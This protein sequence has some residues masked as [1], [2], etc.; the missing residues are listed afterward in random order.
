MW[1]S[2]TSWQ[3]IPMVASERPSTTH[4]TIPLARLETSRSTFAT[5]PILG[6]AI[7]CT[8]S[9]HWSWTWMGRLH[10][11]DL[12]SNKPINI[13]ASLCDNEIQHQHGHANKTKD[14]VQRSTSTSTLYQ[15][16]TSQ[17]GPQHPVVFRPLFPLYAG[18]FFP[19]IRHVSAENS[20]RAGPVLKEFRLVLRAGVWHSTSTLP[21]LHWF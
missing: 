13:L 17:S 1:L 21:A 16:A 10:P 15:C 4:S 19:V 9:T 3:T 20:H 12:L 2:P 18:T 11:T 14:I 7:P 6:L 8:K 5:T